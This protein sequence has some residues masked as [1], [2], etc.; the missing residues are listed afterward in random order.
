M[1]KIS[2]GI[3][4]RADLVVAN[5]CVNMC[6]LACLSAGLDKRTDPSGFPLPAAL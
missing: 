1:A 5:V 6:V 4:Q 2:V 3:N